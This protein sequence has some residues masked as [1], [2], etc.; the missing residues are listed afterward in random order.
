MILL[1]FYRLLDEMAAL[2]PGRAPTVKRY[3]E[4]KHGRGQRKAKNADA[5]RKSRRQM[6]KASRRRN[7][8]A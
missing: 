2:V 3:R 6:A 8:A 4:S 5:L 7:R 1:N